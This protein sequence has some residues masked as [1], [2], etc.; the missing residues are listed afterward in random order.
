MHKIIFII[1]CLLICPPPT[2]SANIKGTIH[3]NGN[4][5]S[6]VYVSDGQNWAITNAQGKYSLQS[7]K[8]NGYIFYILP[9]GYAPEMSKDGFSPKFWA[10]LSSDTKKDETHDFNIMPAS[11]DKYQLIVN[12]DQH[13]ANKSNDVKQF[14]DFFMTSLH[15]TVDSSE[16]PSF[17]LSLGDAVW[18]EYM[19]ETGFG[20]ADY[21]A[22]LRQTKYPCAL[23]HIMGNHDNDSAIPAGDDCDFEASALFRKHFGPRFY[24]MNIGAVHYI[25]LDDVFYRNEMPTDGSP[26][27][28]GAAGSPDF[29]DD[30]VTAEQMGWIKED[31]K[32]ITD[33][34]T[35]IIVGIHS[36]GWKV[37]TNGKYD[38]LPYLKDDNS[39]K[40]AELF[41][42]FSRVKI[43]SGH[44]HY[45]YHAH[46]AAYKNIHE[47][48]IAAVC[49]TWWHT[50]QTSPRH[51]CRDGSPAGYELYTIDG[52]SISW[53]Y[54]PIDPIDSIG[55][56]QMRVY[57][58][59]TIRDFCKGNDAVKKFY[60]YY[61]SLP[62][63]AE[64]PE[65]TIL[66]NI[67][68]YDVDWKV[69]VEENGGKLPVERTTTFDP[70]H[71]LSIGLEKVKIGKKPG[72]DRPILTT[73]M[74][75]C[76]AA[77]ATAPVTITVT[78]SFGRVYKENLIRPKE[79]STS[80]R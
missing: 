67:W 17:A 50:Y 2:F 56:H 35:P 70:L 48:N 77:T 5:V 16:S 57:D 43:L 47:N 7:Q 71:M 15:R 23:Y 14:S 73:H 6:N 21:I 60:N 12:T 44:S 41:K 13:M 26:I 54:K 32:H 38:V 49:G 25:M 39:T 1:T 45:N 30:I 80:M 10:P 74:F 68:D 29:Y 18:D 36:Q 78:D 37:S 58:M 65:N 11:L 75:V 62:N 3:C 72:I 51:L 9:G 42:E 34:S 59:N 53:T 66:I 8:K 63:Y 61:P 28:T 27:P 19:Y 79:F 20:Y 22:L 52:D 46:P 4:G 69:E 76:H 31:L 55:D 40:F 64:I 33:K 24:S